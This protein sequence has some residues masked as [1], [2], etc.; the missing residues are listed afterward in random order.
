MK[1]KT[2]EPRS[3]VRSSWSAVAFYRSRKNT[4]KTV[5]QWRR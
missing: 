1:R 3:L 5:T 4:Q 2:Y